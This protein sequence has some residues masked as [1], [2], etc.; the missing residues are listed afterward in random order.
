VI[1]DLAL[2][3]GGLALLVF[4]ADWLIGAAARLATRYG[5]S[6]FVVGLTVVAFGTS[7]PELVVSAVASLRGSGDIA[8]GNVVGSNIANIAL[9]LGVSAI[10]C[11]IAIQRGMLARDV[12]L[13]VG[14]SVLLYL[15]ILDGELGRFEG[16]VLLAAFAGFMLYVVFA[17]RQQ[18]PGALQVEEVVAEGEARTGRDA[19]LVLVGVVALAVGAHLMVEGASSLARDLGVSEVVIGLSLV[20]IGTSLPELAASIAAARRRE[21]EIIVG[22]IVGSNIFNVTLILGTASVLRPLGVHEH[23]I[24]MEAPIMI[25]ISALLLPLVYTGMR[26]ARWEGWVLL[27]GYAGFL[28]WL[29]YSA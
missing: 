5:V 11:P 10:M 1:L 21:P 24:R 13:M 8:I 16:G 17:A 25:G 14:F 20:A 9:I 18:R 22:N 6:A 2:F 29:F 3:A 28:A 27:A 7:G 15:L 23:V 26:L 4:G 12:P 19:A